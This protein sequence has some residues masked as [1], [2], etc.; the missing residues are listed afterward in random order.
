MPIL[1]LQSGQVQECLLGASELLQFVLQAPLAPS[2]TPP[3]GSA[4]GLPA[5]LSPLHLLAP[6]GL[7]FELLAQTPF[8]FIYYFLLVVPVFALVGETADG[9]CTK[10]RDVLGRIAQTVGQQ[11]LDL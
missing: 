5:L 3:L 8:V 7:L 2:L 9:S 11:G 1:Q 10:E 4:Q 6:E